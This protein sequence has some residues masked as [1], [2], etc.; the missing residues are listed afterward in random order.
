MR[1]GRNCCGCWRILYEFGVR[2]SRCALVCASWARPGCV[3]C[4]V[5]WI[6][7]H[8][9]IDDGRRTTGVGVS[10]VERGWPCTSHITSR[11][12]RVVDRK[13]QR[14]VRF[15]VS[16]K[17][18]KRYY[19]PWVRRCTW[20]S[21]RIRQFAIPGHTTALLPEQGALLRRARRALVYYTPQN[22]CTPHHN[23]TADHTPHSNRHPRALARIAWLHPRQ[24]T[25][26]SER[27]ALIPARSQ[28][29]RG[30]GKG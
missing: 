27:R 26:S 19:L 9:D 21:A 12:G 24:R 14:T 4:R 1:T 5:P 23:T 29:A 6:D 30:W 3:V 15:R 18:K 17:T 13:T 25:A 2:S 20:G 8:T 22:T 28:L 11:G 10:G 7:E 16:G